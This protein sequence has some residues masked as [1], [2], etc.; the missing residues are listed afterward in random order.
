VTD[1]FAAAVIVLLV[2][3]GLLLGGLSLIGLLVAVVASLDPDEAA[4]NRFVKP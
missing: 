2:P 3:A 4:A 1:E